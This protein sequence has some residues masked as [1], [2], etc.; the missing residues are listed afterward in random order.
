ME[1]WKKKKKTI[2]NTGVQFWENT[3][4]TFF[5]FSGQTIVLNVGMI[6]ISIQKMTKYSLEQTELHLCLRVE[7]Q[8]ET[9]HLLF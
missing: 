5:L 1:E 6:Y 8:K 3:L 4:L 7:H 9:L 2:K